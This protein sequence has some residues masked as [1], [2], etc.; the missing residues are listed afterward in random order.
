M[1]GW[2]WP[3]ACSCLTSLIIVMTRLI[4]TVQQ[5]GADNHY[6][7]CMQGYCKC[8]HCRGT[9]FRANWLGVNPK[10]EV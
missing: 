4:N 3:P 5:A 7:A 1:L 2:P 6:G 9:G 10:L 8:E